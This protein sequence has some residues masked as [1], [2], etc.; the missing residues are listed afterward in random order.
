LPIGAVL[1]G[2]ARA[3]CGD[4]DEG[5]SWIEDGID[6]Y[7]VRGSTVMLPYFLARKAEALH[8]ADRASKALETIKEAEELVERT[9]ERW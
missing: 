7:R 3:A 2:W 1:R 5:I 4:T 6:D 9:E 8:L